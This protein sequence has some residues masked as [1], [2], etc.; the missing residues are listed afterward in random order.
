[1]LPNCGLLV[2]CSRALLQ[3]H[4]FAIRKATKMTF[5]LSGKSTILRATCAV[6]L[7]ANCGLMVPCL[8]AHVPRFDA[9]MLRMFLSDSPAESKSSWQMEAIDTRNILAD[10][11]EKSLVLVSS[12]KTFISESLLRPLP[13]FTMFLLCF[14]TKQSLLAAGTEKTFVPTLFC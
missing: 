13:R 2:P 9:Y 14:C 10:V 4:T 7:L 6:S 5:S 11:T 12:Y 8:S 3:A 1:M